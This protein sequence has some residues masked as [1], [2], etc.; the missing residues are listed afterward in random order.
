MKNYIFLLSACLIP[1]GMSAQD[2]KLNEQGYFSCSGSDVMVFDDQYPEGHAGGITVVQQDNRMA[3]LGDVRFEATPGQWQGL[4]KFIKKEI[5]R[6]QNEITVWMAYPDSSKHAA[7]FN[8]M[9][10]PDFQFNYIVKVKGEG[11]HLDVRV[12]I[13]RPMPVQ[14]AGKLGF[15]LELQ[16]SQLYG[17]PY[18]MDNQAG[19]F[20]HQAMGPTMQTS[21][22]VDRLGDYF[23]PD[24]TMKWGERVFHEHRD[25]ANIAQLMGD[26]AIYNPMRADNL[27]SK[28]LAE[29]EHFVL[30]PQAQNRVDIV[31]EK[32]SLRLYDGR[33]NHQ[34]GW[35]VLR[36]EF[37]AGAQG[38]VAHWQ[39]RPQVDANWR[40]TPVVQTSQLGYHPTQTKIAVV[41]LDKRD[42]SSAEVQVLRIDQEGT[43]CVMQGEAKEWGNFNRYHYRTFDFSQIQEPG[44]YQVKYGEQTSPMFR[45]AENIFDQGVWQAEIEY[46][47]PIQMCHMRV[48]EK[49]HCW[50][51]VCHMDDAQMAPVGF[52]YIDGYTQ[53]PSTLCKYQP[54]DQI[55]GLAVGGWHDAGDWDL[56]VESQSME[57]WQLC[58]MVENLGAY[59]DET[60]I[61]QK[62]HL[63][64]IHQP[65]GVNDYLQQIEHGALTLM[66]GWKSLG[67]LYRGIICPTVRQYVFLG[68]AGSHTDRIAGT[69]DDRWVFTEQ[70]PH[71]ELGVAGRLAT[72]ARVL[73]GYND[74]LSVQCLE[75]ARTIY[76]TYQT[77]K[78]PFLVESQLEAAVE[79]YLT[80]GEKQYSDFVLKQQDFVC[81]HIEQ[82][83]WFIGRFDKAIG[84]KKFSAAIRK[85]LPAVQEK[86][87]QMMQMNP[88]RVGSGRG[89]FSSGSWAAQ[90]E[91]FRY[92]MLH[93][94]YP[95]LF[96]TEYMSYCVEWALGMHPG[97]NR[98]TFVGGVGQEA[99]RLTYGSNRADWSYIPGAVIPG[100]N[101]IHP[102]LPELLNYPF[103]W[104]QREFCVDGANTAYHYI[105]MDLAHNYRTAK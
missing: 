19:Q 56:R 34:N 36:T 10:Y 31:S 84:N 20:P 69:A 51:D 88:Y 14:Y 59:W 8:P 46:F 42:S 79:L 60:T 63:V 4:P 43:K 15:N 45:I 102:D 41:E 40:Y 48:N 71:R 81:Q 37:E 72:I 80:T 3:T 98:S 22:N 5:N 100:T 21:S 7:G 6:A 96:S 30:Q 68:D 28:P 29:G 90:H 103:L 50:H 97:R 58:M 93:D 77:E 39:I 87:Q 86:F 18:L 54:G 85:A 99:A 55:P 61:D 25:P 105:V 67:R 66:A 101:L 57:P 23:Q 76:A 27:I 92:A 74:T 33:I 95:D 91:G 65:D 73:K 44:L 62:N 12:E 53:G 104:Q 9:F 82:C 47:L 64:E 38:E 32:G 26:S 16:P 52:N 13:D 83:G 78:M 89:G 35:F 17:M 94:S 49:Y 70:N 24:V 11:D 2:F 1:G 75:A